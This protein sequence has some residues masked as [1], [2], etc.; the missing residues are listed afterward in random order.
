M[1]NRHHF[2]NALRKWTRTL[3][4]YVSMLGLC[5]ILFF[6]ATG[7]MLNH[8]EWFGFEEPSVRTVEGTLPAA[9][10]TGP[11]ELAVAESLRKDFHATGLVDS[12]ETYDDEIV[13]VFVS[14]GR[15]VQATIARPDG[16][17]ELELESHGIAGRLVD[18]HRGGETGAA[19]RFLIDVTSVILVFA[20]L[21]G[22]LLWSFVPKWRT[23]GLGAAIFSLAICGVVYFLLV[24]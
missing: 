13:V 12:F 22:L 24:P 9:I 6:A 11:D 2:R 23:I 8:E 15:R 16:E 3:H 4:I 17:T 7:F 18:L 19:W 21:S 14:P 1:M 20:A 5:A 10:L